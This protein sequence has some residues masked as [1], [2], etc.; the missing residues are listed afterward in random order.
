MGG[1]EPPSIPRRRSRPVRVG[2][3]TI[4]GDAPVSVQSMTNTP[5]ADADA[6]AAQ[7]AALAEAGADLVRVA[8]PTREDTAALRDIVRRSPV[9]IIADVHFHFDRALEA[10]DAGAAKIRLN[11]GNIA[12]R[13]QVRRV[14]RSAADAGVAIRVGVNEGSVVSRTDATRREAERARPLDELMVEK[15]VEYLTVFEEEGFGELVLSA[16]SHDP[17]LCVLANRRLAERWDYPL[18]LGVTHAGPAE[19]AVVRSAA[20]LG[21]LLM[22]GI[23]ETVRVSIAG[24]PVD[25]V[26]VAL[27]LLWSL[28]LRERRGVELIACPTCGRLQTDILPIL[29][30]V[31]RRLA[32]VKAPLTV[33][34]MGCVVN[35]PGEADS[36]DVA[37]CA[38]R[39]RA[40]LYSRGKRLRTVD[41]DEIADAVVAE[42][43]R[44]AG[45]VRE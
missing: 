18:H 17:Y 19:T 29:A 44:L 11:P 36:A 42:T 25:E 30:E 27:E 34:V 5:T 14:V 4:G 31:R 38:G 41:A 16:K 28:R 45:D 43:L 15:L 35:G 33:A 3:V 23:G 10:I 32:G 20:M 37:I 40:V 12:D 1:M 13:E 26:R 39:D 9:P 24:D 22:E 21:A 2:D 6:T 7:V 8:V